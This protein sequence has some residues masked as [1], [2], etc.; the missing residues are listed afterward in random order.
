MPSSRQSI[1][2]ALVRQPR[3]VEKAAPRAVLDLDDPEVR[4]EAALEHHDDDVFVYHWTLAHHTSICR[5]CKLYD[6]ENHR[7]LNFRG[8][9]T[10]EP[11]PVLRALRE[12]N[13]PSRR[14]K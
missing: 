12:G 3:L 10:S 13:G 14:K 4:V 1:K 9:P 7:W 6:Y 2:E 8:R 11:N 5:R